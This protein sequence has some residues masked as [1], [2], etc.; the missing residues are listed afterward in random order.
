MYKRGEPEPVG[1]GRPS[2]PAVFPSSIRTTVQY[3]ALIEPNPS[4]VIVIA[5]SRVIHPIRRPPARP[6]SELI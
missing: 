3:Q 5:P 2:R 6:S 1:W 4:Q